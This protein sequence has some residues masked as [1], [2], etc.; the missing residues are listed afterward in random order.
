MPAQAGDQDPTRTQPPAHAGQQP[1]VV[2][3]WNVDQ[4]VERDHAIKRRRPE[5]HRRHVGLQEHRS[6]GIQPRQANHL[7][8]DVDTD[9]GEPAAQHPRHRDARTAPKLQHP[10]NGWQ[11]CGQTSA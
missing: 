1:G 6:W 9:D 5:R 3:P 11:A 4:G 8:G 7:L 2:D 10:S